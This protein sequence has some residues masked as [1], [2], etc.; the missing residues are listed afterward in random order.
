MGT[1]G[2]TADRGTLYP[3]PLLHQPIGIPFPASK[4]QAFPPFLLKPIRDHHV[5]SAMDRIGGQ[6]PG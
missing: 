1:V 4:K 6:G 5:I 3:S 2:W